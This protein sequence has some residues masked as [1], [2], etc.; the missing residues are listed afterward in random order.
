[1]ALSIDNVIDEFLSWYKDTFTTQSYGDGIRTW[2]TFGMAKPLSQQNI[3]EFFDRKALND[4]YVKVVSTKNKPTEPYAFIQA[5][6][7]FLYSLHKSFVTRH[8]SRLMF[9]RD[10]CAQKNYHNWNAIN[11]AFGRFLAERDYHSV[12]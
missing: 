5:E 3:A 6:I 12:T 11:Y 2:C 1:M 9:Y 8:K 7:D 10:D 4:K